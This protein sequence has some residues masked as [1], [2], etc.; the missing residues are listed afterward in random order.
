M[1]NIRTLAGGCL[2]GTKPWKYGTKFVKQYL[3]G[4][5]LR[6]TSVHSVFRH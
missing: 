3:V 1:H 6:L 4:L 5:A 2:V